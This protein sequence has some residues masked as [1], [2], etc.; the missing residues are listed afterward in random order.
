MT[1][2]RTEPRVKI[3]KLE[4]GAAI[5]IDGEEEFISEVEGACLSTLTRTESKAIIET[6]YMIT[7]DGLQDTGDKF[8]SSY[9]HRIVHAG[10]DEYDKLDE[11]LAEYEKKNAGVRS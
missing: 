11:K 1:E 10:E 9:A 5:Q 7:R 3:S 2:T 8:L 4:V 6:A